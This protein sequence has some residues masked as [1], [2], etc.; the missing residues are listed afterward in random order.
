[1]RV[2][3]FRHEWELDEEL[4]EEALMTQGNEKNKIQ[5]KMKES[6]E[7]LT[8]QSVSSGKWYKKIKSY[9]TREQL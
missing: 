6:F 8:Q 3:L 9:E 2:L 1:M 5:Q 7:V 4:D